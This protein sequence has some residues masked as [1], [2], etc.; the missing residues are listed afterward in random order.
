MLIEEKSLKPAAFSLSVFNAP[1]ALA[2]IA[3]NLEGGYSAVYPGQNSFA[4]GF[5]AAAAPV[6]CGRAENI[7]LVYADEM[8]P[9]EYSGLCSEACEPLAFGVLLSRKPG[10]QAVPAANPEFDSPRAFL[11]KTILT[12]QGSRE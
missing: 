1:V 5:A 6:L 9:L 7:L 11:K 2:T 12:D 3:L 10:P 8:P 4:A